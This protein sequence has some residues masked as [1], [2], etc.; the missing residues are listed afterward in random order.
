VSANFFTA[1]EASPALGRTFASEEDQPGRAAVVILSHGLWSRRYASDP[2]IVGRVVSLDG[3]PA[4]VAGV[5]PPG[6]EFPVP[7]DLWIPLQLTAEQR[8][9]RARRNLRAFGL[10][11][12]GVTAQQAQAEMSTFAKQLSNPTR[13][14]IRSGWCA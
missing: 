6:F 9:D 1:L 11:A 7:T 5:M 12:P 2:Q 10:L 4:T 8:A 14:R 3:K 13:Q